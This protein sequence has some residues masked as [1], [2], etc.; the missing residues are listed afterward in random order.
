M[1]STYGKQAAFLSAGSYHHHIGLNTWHSA[2]SPPAPANG[3]V[4]VVIPRK[5]LMYCWYLIETFSV[6]LKLLQFFSRNG[7]LNFL[8]TL[9]N[10]YTPNN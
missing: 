8:K 3:V 10:Y 1:T 7:I 9:H 2:G 4:S 5:E 6:L